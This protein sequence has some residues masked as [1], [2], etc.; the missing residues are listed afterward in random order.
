MSQY[1]SAVAS[2]TSL[3]VVVAQIDPTLPRYGTDF[4][5]QPPFLK[6]GQ[7]LHRPRRY[8]PRFSRHISLKR[9]PQL[10][11]LATRRRRKRVFTIT[12]HR[13]GLGN[14]REE[15]FGLSLQ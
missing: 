3:R 15:A 12:R 14:G 5:P 11:Q 4:I 13:Q 7:R 10:A 6:R 8:S 2:L 9:V 1:R